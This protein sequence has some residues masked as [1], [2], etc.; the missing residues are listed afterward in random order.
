MQAINAAALKET[1]QNSKK[2][3]RSDRPQST[4][5][6]RY[7]AKRGKHAGKWCQRSTDVD[8]IIQAQRGKKAVFLVQ[9]TF[10]VFDGCL[11]SLDAAEKA[12]YFWYVA[13]VNKTTKGQRANPETFETLEGWEQLDIGTTITAE[14][15]DGS[16]IPFPISSLGDIVNAYPGANLSIR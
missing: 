16:W 6:P 7:L 12:Y 8:N 5:V 10:Y 4:E 14:A 9:H 11:D 15:G 2:A 1:I 3:Q 13:P